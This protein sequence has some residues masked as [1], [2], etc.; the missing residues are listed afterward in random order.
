MCLRWKTSL[1]VLST[2]HTQVKSKLK[3]SLLGHLTQYSVWR[4][5]RSGSDQSVGST[6]KQLESW[7]L[8]CLESLSPSASKNKKQ[9]YNHRK[10]KKHDWK[11]KVA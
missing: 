7:F 8:F 10:K 3:H 5:S 4:C 9:K 2:V 1:T 11:K 6:T